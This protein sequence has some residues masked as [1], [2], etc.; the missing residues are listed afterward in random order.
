[1]IILGIDPGSRKTG[2]GLIQQMGNTI[3]HI[4]HGVI[5]LTQESLIH[6]LGHIHQT[7]K[8]LITQH[9]PDHMAIEQ[10]FVHINPQSALK[11]GQARGAALAA[12]NAQTLSGYEY[13]PREIKLA[14]A[15]FGAANKSQIQQMI[16]ALLSLKTTP[17][18]DAADA[19]AVAICHC[20][21]YKLK[22]TLAQAKVT[23]GCTKTDKI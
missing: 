19:L 3:T 6:R 1:M 15:G 2:F 4:D 7:I 10:V 16:K 8:A 22:K 9:Q 11:L 17:P 12:C 21:Q 14:V 13:S 23:A 20:H 5:S 18:S